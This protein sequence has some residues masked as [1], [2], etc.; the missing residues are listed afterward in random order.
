MCLSISRTHPKLSSAAVWG[1][2][3]SLRCLDLFGEVPGARGLIPHAC[4][5]STQFTPFTLSQ[6]SQRGQAPQLRLIA[7]TYSCDLQLC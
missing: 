6:R 2:N 4:T 3:C 7:A 5:Q 1:L